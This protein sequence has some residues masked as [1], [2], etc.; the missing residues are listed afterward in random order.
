MNTVTTLAVEGMSCTGCENNVQFALSAMGGVEEVEA[1]HR[2]DTVR[3]V[4]DEALVDERALKA[5]IDAMG[6]TT[7]P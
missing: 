6:Y 5:A 7:T 2:A 1:D 3:V 4:F